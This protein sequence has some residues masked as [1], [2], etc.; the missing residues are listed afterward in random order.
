MRES[1]LTKWL[2]ANNLVTKNKQFTHLCMD[3]G[4]LN[5]TTDDIH[6]F[7][8]KFSETY[9]NESHFICET[10][11]NVRKFYCDFDIVF[12]RP[13][14]IR[15]LQPYLEIMYNTIKEYFNYDSTIII[16]STTP[17]SKEMEDG[18]F[19]TGIHYIWK[20]FFVTKDISKVLAMFFIQEFKKYDLEHSEE[21]LGLLWEDVVD[22]QVYNSGL[23]MIGS[24]KIGKKDGKFVEDNRMYMPE[25]VYPE[26]LEY[27][28]GNM[29]KYLCDCSVRNLYGGE[30][31][32]AVKR[33][34]IDIQYNNNINI[35]EGNIENVEEKIAAIK[36]FIRL[37]KCPKQ[38]N[39]DIISI[40]YLKNHYTVFS[41]SR[42]CLNNGKDHNGKNIYFK[43]FK[44]GLE[45]NCTCMCKELKNG[46]KIECSKYQSPKYKL[47]KDVFKILFPNE[48]ISSRSLQKIDYDGIFPNNLLLTPEGIDAYLMKSARTIEH[49][50]KKYVY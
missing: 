31:F 20:N 5:I 27:L 43:I 12:E 35:E 22:I 32:N 23:R 26:D 19:K 21:S 48:R 42:Y 49:L 24:K 3:G 2:F 38:W 14:S 4:K 9:K 16:C 8:T 46:K 10:V 36:M 41:K 44:S 39:D 30:P 17:Q 40:K 6:E 47:T 29:F 7:F 25:M 37:S 15:E 11:D 50:K 45:Q 18:R 33:I 28:D 34:P 1:K 13:I